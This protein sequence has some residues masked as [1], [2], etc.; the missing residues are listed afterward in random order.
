VPEPNTLLKTGLGLLRRAW[1]WALFVLGLLTFLAWLWFPSDQTPKG[2]YYRLV[3]AVNRGEAADIFPYVETA[4]QHA[5]FTIGDYT[6]KARERVNVAYP[7]PNRTQEL[8][9]LAELADVE[10]GPGVFAVYAVRYAWIQRLRR[11]LSGI[12]KI[13]E[14]QDRA[15][16]ETAR[17]TRYA[18]R[19]RENGIWG[20]TLFTARLVEDSEKAARD[21]AQ[22]EAAARDYESASR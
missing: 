7:E 21:F 10:P 22:I 9:R 20:L 15:T 19:K 11:D 16:I 13:E 8:A 18:F 2:A 5:A 12:A 6:R 4:A 17:G 3:V 14:E 1:V